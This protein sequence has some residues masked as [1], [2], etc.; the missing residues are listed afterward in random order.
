[1]CNWS[2]FT[3]YYITVVLVLLFLDFYV[4][5]LVIIK[6]NSNKTCIK[7]QTLCFLDE[8]WKIHWIWIYGCQF[9]TYFP[10][11]LIFM[12]S[13]YQVLLI[14]RKK[15]QWNQ[16]NK[17]KFKNYSGTVAVL[18]WAISSKSRP[19]SLRINKKSTE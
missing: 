16:L 9:E 12:C 13:R 3:S 1:M 11:L 14:F 5:F 8:Y 7:K 10:V 15:A 18:R 2:I 17:P 6:Q 4:T 19:W